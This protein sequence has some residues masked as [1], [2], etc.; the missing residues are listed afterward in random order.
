[1]VSLPFP[2]VDGSSAA[3]THR[4]SLSSITSQFLFYSTAETCHS[5]PIK[6]LNVILFFQIVAS[7]LFF[8]VGLSDTLEVPENPR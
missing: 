1:V 3:P 7:S 4:F 8:R 6:T 2:V 5:A